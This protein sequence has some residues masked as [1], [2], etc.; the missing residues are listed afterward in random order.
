MDEDGFWAVIEECRA[1]GGGDL[2]TLINSL[3]RRLS[4]LSADEASGF[5]D[6]WQA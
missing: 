3:E 4:L 5:F 6:R 2:E 1:D